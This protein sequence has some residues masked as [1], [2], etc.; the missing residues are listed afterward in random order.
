MQPNY[1]CRQVLPEDLELL[2]VQYLVYSAKMSYGLGYIECR[3]F[4]YEIAVKNNIAVPESW[5]VNKMAG[6]EWVRSFMKRHNNISLRQ[7]ESCSLS[8]ATSFN[9]F[10]VSLFFNKL[11]DVMN[12][13]STFGD[14]S[15][16]FNIDETGV[17]TVQSPH[18]VIAQKGVKRLNQV[19]SGERGV[20]VTVCCIINAYG[21]ALPPVFIFP[22]VHFKM[23]ML[24]GAPP[25]SMGLACQSGWMNTDLFIQTLQHFIKITNSSKDNPS[26][27][28][29]DNHESHVSINSIDLAKENG[30]TLL[31]L[32]P[33]CSN[34][35]QPLDVSV[36]GPFKSYYNSALD[37]WL[38]RHP[39]KPI[40]IY[41]VAECVNVAFEKSMTPKNIIS[42][43]KN[44]GIFPFDQNIFT[45]DDYLVSAVTDRPDENITNNINEQV[46]ENLTLNE[47]LLSS[48]QLTKV[49][50]TLTTE[51]TT[52]N[53]TTNSMLVSPENV[54]PYPKAEPRKEN[55]NKKRKKYSTILTDTPEKLRL[56]EAAKLKNKH[57]VKKV[58][59]TPTVKTKKISVNEN[60]NKEE[61]VDDSLNE[62][63]INML[64]DDQISDLESFTIDDLTG[65][66]ELD[67]D[68]T[69]GDY[70][71]V[72]FKTKD[73]KNKFKT[74]FYV[75]K[76]IKNKDEDGDLEIS[77]MRKYKNFTTC[78]FVLPNIPDLASVNLNDIKALLPPPKVTGKTTRQ[79]SC[80]VFEVDLRHIEN[81]R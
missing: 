59:Y 37:S 42:G 11:K 40:D 69:E 48:K 28:I 71:L 13:H 55:S 12:R 25:G 44:T 46:T 30:V 64:F 27:L 22:R 72:E 1:K 21:S 76:I 5:N 8:R 19:T 74:V 67:R 29:M 38:Q 16:I 43:F 80:Y 61:E 66:E 77:Y 23:H 31:T 9:P 6:I 75:G 52:K 14:G 63:D 24:R 79:Q 3:K 34:R 73:P 47:E 68:P 78:K 81:L 58:L 51:K 41:H 50:D 60:L 65:F 39:G 36:Y 56:E 70:V 49:V 17:T 62:N 35:L 20:L 32:P 33:H 18:K 2:L 15:R 57:K 53:K 26:L 45:D 4:S 7:P 54:R 10:N